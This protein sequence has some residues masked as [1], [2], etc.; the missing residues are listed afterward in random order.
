M[1]NKAIH[2]PNPITVLRAVP[3]RFAKTTLTAN[4]LDNNVYASDPQQWAR[5]QKRDKA[6]AEVCELPSDVFEN[7]RRGDV[8]TRA[9]AFDLAI[10][11]PYVA[12]RAGVDWSVDLC[13]AHARRYLDLIT[14]TEAQ[15][16]AYPG[17]NET[18]E[19]MRRRYPANLN[20]ALTDCPL[21]LALLRSEAPGT[22]PFFDA[23][24]GVQT[25]VP[26]V[27]KTSKYWPVVEMCVEWTENVIAEHAKQTRFL[28]AL[29]Q[30]ACK[31]SS[32][33]LEELLKLENFIDLS[34]VRVTMSGD[35]AKDGMVARN[36]SPSVKSASFIH[37]RIGRHEQLGTSGVK[38]DLVVTSDFREILPFLG[39]EFRR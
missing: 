31:P 35:K 11:I 6:I 30:Q 17:V 34:D 29:S 13:M 16:E 1:T 15:I 27:M 18:F 21:W 33:G 23:V 7:V 14:E 12:H 24:L 39:Q 32:A 37:T 8:S 28:L 20:A 22:L 19:T 10:T 25:F 2:T 26:E 3:S 9:E 36:L 38:A 5:E 4:D